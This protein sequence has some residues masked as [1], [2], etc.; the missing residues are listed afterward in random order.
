MLGSS[1]S[2]R[3]WATYARGE[4]LSALGEPDATDAYMLAIS[5]ARAVGN[6]F[7]VS[8]S[9]VSLASEHS[10]ARSHRQALYAFAD[11]LHAYARLLDSLAR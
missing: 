2:D 4:A 10:R 3:A 8:V 6:P 1:P 11:C 9:Q 7:V 5:L